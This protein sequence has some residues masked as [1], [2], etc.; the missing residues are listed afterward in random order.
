MALET[1][2]APDTPIFAAN[3]LKL[4]QLAGSGA[5]ANVAKYI[6]PLIRLRFRADA[7]DGSIL[8]KE[9]GVEVPSVVECLSLTAKK[10]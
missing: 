9:P 5:A 2:S 6:G 4:G 1:I 7:A 3:I 10:S 8:H